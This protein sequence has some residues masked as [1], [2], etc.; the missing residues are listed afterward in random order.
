M[1]AGMEDMAWMSG[2]WACE[3]WGGTFEEHWSCPDGGTMLGYGRLL[4][5]GRTTF[6]E[7]MTL[8]AM[9]GELTMWIV[10][11]P[12]SHGPVEA[13]PFRL[14]SAGAGEMVFRNPDNNFPNTIRYRTEEPDR[15]TCDISGVRDGEPKSDTFRFV[16]AS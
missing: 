6:A 5:G 7:H 14:A 16:R 8:E 3:I 2:S 1:S 13:I 15:M 12:L 9:A 11:K 4:K 10:V